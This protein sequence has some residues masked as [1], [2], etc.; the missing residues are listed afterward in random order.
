MKWEQHD[1]EV[2]DA[3]GFLSQIRFRAYVDRKNF[4][5]PGNPFEPIPGMEKEFEDALKTIQRV[6]IIRWELDTRMKRRR[7]AD[8][9]KRKPDQ[10]RADAIEDSRRLQRDYKRPYYQFGVEAVQFQYYFA[11]IMRQKSAEVGEYLPILEINSV[12]NKDA[13]IQSLQPFVKNGYIKFSRKHK[14]LYKQMT[15]YP[16]GKN[17]DG[18]DGLQMAVK[19]ALDIKVGRKVDY[20]SVIARALD[21]KRGAY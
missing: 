19:L 11:E 13:R 15:E 1:A 10:I 4:A 12:Q 6:N 18:P 21:F 5:K 8:I 7:L 2:K 20:R 16:M 17:D 14:T 3:L 9:E